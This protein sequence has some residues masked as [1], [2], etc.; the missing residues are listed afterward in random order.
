M[1]GG[2]V[3]FFFFFLG[4]NKE[5]GD[6]VASLMMIYNTGGSLA[7]LNCGGLQLVK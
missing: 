2:K 5:G 7:I 4:D 3:E 1:N 6:C